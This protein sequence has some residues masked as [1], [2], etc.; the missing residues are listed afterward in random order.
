MKKNRV[1]NHN[2][3][4]G[5]YAFHYAGLKADKYGLYEYVEDMG[6]PIKTPERIRRYLNKRNLGK[7]NN[8][9]R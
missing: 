7:I 5:K 3:P 6:T 4:Y 9:L 8:I 2:G 1:G